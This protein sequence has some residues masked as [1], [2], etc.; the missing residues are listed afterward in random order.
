MAHQWGQC[1]S[2]VFLGFAL[3][4]LDELSAARRHFEEGL[5]LARR[6]DS[7]VW[8]GYALDGLGWVASRQGRLKEAQSHLIASLDLRREFSAH[9]NIAESLDSLAG[10]AAQCGHALRAC[11]LA[12]AAEALRQRVGQT[13]VLARRQMRDGWMTTVL[14]KFG[15][16][17]EEAFS[18]GTQLSIEEA[19]ALAHEGDKPVAP[20]IEPQLTLAPHLDVAL[21]PRER[22]VVVLLARGLSNPQIADELVISPRTAQRHVENI[23][24]KLGFG[25]RA[26]V[27]AW[28]VSSGLV[29]SASVFEPSD[30]ASVQPH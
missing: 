24:A 22:Q 26:Q 6:Q 1:I 28:S 7:P 3:F 11:Q 25:S 19:I 5:R 9:A 30:L 23:L 27:A 4:S 13:L 2:L 14:H 18:A 17:A 21:T 12:G 10:V 8:V 15:E 16:H 20:T 29:P